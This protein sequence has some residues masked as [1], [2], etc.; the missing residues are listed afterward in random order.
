[1]DK[2]Q[3]SERD[4]ISKYITPAVVNSGWDLKKQIREEV[5]FTD[6]RIIVRKRLVTR[7]ERKRADIILYYKSNI[8]IAI[9]EAKDNKHSIGAGMQQAL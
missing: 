4:I 6:G 8:P 9:I 7:G 2:K 3:L 5:P 1:M